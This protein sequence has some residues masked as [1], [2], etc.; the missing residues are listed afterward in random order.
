MD[1]TSHSL[2]G[3]WDNLLS[4]QPDRVRLAFDSLD[5]DGKNTVLAHLQRMASE[6]G[7]LPEQRD[8]AIAALQALENQSTQG[9]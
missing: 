9:K 8:S 5:P 1:G 3:L 4:R 2:E 7:W 6:S